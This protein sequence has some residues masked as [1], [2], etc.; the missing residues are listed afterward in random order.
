MRRLTAVLGTVAALGAPAAARAAGV[1]P[2]FSPG[3]WTGT[4]RIEGGIDTGN[5]HASGQGSGAFS[6]TVAREGFV[7]GGNLSV[8][9]SIVTTSPQGTFNSSTSGAIPLHG[10][11]RNVSGAGTMTFH[12]DTP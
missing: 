4:M 1:A 7:T 2:G 11:A 3:R 8:S 5:L 9:E 12:I 6:F 10:D